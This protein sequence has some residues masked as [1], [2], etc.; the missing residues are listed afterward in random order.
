MSE[1]LKTAIYT[2]VE[3]S[4][5]SVLILI[6]VFFGGYAKDSLVLKNNQD[7]GTREIIEYRDLYEI[8]KGKRIDVT[9]KGLSN[10]NY[11]NIR[12]VGY[13]STKRTNFRNWVLN[14]NTSNVVKGE[15]ILNFISKKGGKYDILIYFNGKTNDIFKRSSTFTLHNLL[16]KYGLGRNSSSNNIYIY[17]TGTSRITE[18]VVYI[19]AAGQ[20]ENMVFFLRECMGSY[21]TSEFYCSSIFDSTDNTYL[22]VVFKLK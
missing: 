20:D 6:I 15:D 7:A 14:E 21:I 22:A 10:N 1:E 17:P 12:R 9:T 5:F 16:E 2:A 13:Y 8:D 3:I 11:L 4:V 18:D 19:R